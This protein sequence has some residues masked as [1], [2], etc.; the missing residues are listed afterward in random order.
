MPHFTL[1]YSR[2]VE[3]LCDLETVMASI[4]E[5]GATSGVMNPDDIKIRALAYDTFRFE[6]GIESF[7]HLTVS[8]LEGRSDQQKEHLALRLRERLAERCPSVDSISID[9]RD[10]NPV[11]YKKR[12]LDAR[13]R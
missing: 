6:G 8:M 3:R 2:G 10:M 11:A 12:L 7:L 5:V 13:A 4:Y 1:E 9:V